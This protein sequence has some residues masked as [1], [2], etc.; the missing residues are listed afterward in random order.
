[1]KTKPFILIICV[2]LV[3]NILTLILWVKE[4]NHS[5]SAETKAGSEVV[6]TIDGDTLTREDWLYSLEQKYGE[7]ELRTLINQ[8]VIGKV[9]KKYDVS[10]SDKEIEQEFAF[11]QSV[12]N[13]Y[14]EEYIE[15]EESLKAQIKSDLLLEELLTKDVQV[16][17]KEM[18]TF[19][20]QNEHLYTFPKMFKL[21]QIKVANQS[22]ANQVITELED[23][24]NFEAL[25]MERSI[26]EQSAHLGGEIGFIPVEGELLSSEAVTELESLS[27]GEWSQ[28]VQMDSEYVI[29]YVEDFMKERH[30]SFK[31]VKQQIRRQLA[32]EQIETPMHPEVFWDEVKVD[33]F[34]ESKQ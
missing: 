10:I 24:S 20:E 3:T 33:W 28:P 31:D 12:Y 1:M 6:A 11:I 25:A 7:Q 32:L 29:F 22:D 17:E 34:Y 30:Y 15:D 8:E 21:K 4:D 9:A 5:K 16:S 14:D 19:Y 2:L 13:A 18:K 27:K 23:G 26:D